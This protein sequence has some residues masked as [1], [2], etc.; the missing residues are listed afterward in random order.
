MTYNKGQEEDKG[1]GWNIEI[2]DKCVIGGY[3]YVTLSIIGPD[4]KDHGALIAIHSVADQLRKGI[5]TY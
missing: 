4:G 2:K 5:P 1:D 3:N